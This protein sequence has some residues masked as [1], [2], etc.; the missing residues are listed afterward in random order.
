M[1]FIAHLKI[2]Q[3]LLA[4]LLFPILGLLYF[5]T[6][7]LIEKIQT[8]HDMQGL[9]E[10]TELSIHLSQVVHTIQLER[11]ASSLFLNHQGR[12][13]ASELAHYQERSDQ[14][15]RTVQEFKTQFQTF[16]SESFKLHLDEVFSTFE[17]LQKLREK[18]NNLTTTPKEAIGQYNVINRQLFQFI[19]NTTQLRNYREV[20][21]LKLAYINLLHAKEKAGQER[22]LLVTVFSQ[23]HLKS[24]QFQEFIRLIS[25][26]DT[27]L[28]HEIMNYLTEEQKEFLKSK[29][30]PNNS[31]IE[32]TERLREV[33]YTAA[34]T[35][36]G[37][38]LETV[39]PEHWFT[40]QTRKIEVLKEVA[41]KLAHD[42]YLQAENTQY[43]AFSGFIY[44]S[45]LIGVVLIFSIFFFMTVWYNT[46]QRL[47]QT[48][49]MAN[50]TST[51]HLEELETDGQETM[52]RDEIGQLF[53]ALVDMRSQ[54][55]ARIEANKQISEAALRINQALD[56]V[57]THV[58][59]TDEHYRIIYLNKAAQQ[60]FTREE[61]RFQKYLPQ[62]KA[63]NILGTAFDFFHKNPSH[64]QKLVSGLTSSHH[65]RIVIDNLVLDH[66]IT[67]VIN[68]EGQRLGLV[69]EFNNRS[70][71]VGTEQ[72][73]NQVIQAA[74]QSDFSQRIQLL[75]KTGFFR[76]FSEGINQILDFNQ[77][78]VEDIMH[79]VSALAK[80][81]LTQTIQNEYR[82]AFD[83]LKND[84]NSTIDKLVEIMIVIKETAETIEHTAEELSIGNSRLNQRTETQAASLE[85]TAASMQ[86][87]TSSVQ[88]NAD[89]TKQASLLA[90]QAKIHAEKGGEVVNC[91]IRA[92]TE[93]SNSSARITE[94]IAVI[95]DIAFQ[96]N[97][98]ALNAAVEAARAGEQGRGFAVVATEVRNLAQRSAEAAK[99]IKRLI[100]DSVVKVEEGAKLADQSGKTLTEI[101]TSVKKVSDIIAEIAA[102]TQ[103]QS[104][105]IHQV[106][107]VV[108][109][110][111]EMT[112]QNASMVEEASAASETLRRQVQELKTQVAV[113]KISSIVE[114]TA[115][116]NIS[117]LKDSPRHLKH[118]PPEGEWQDF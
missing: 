44:L 115:S 4:M 12:Q 75:G 103:E 34:H 8:V 116:L 69:L 64:Q 53:K 29:L 114:K 19:L 95:N 18:I 72:E 82:G 66:I 96:T 79:I 49:G 60:L 46:T 62:F 36:E 1:K 57:T 94:I 27:Y 85:Q 65:A 23:T 74:S 81:D 11:G 14:A 67:P 61:V 101:V 58:L 63:S 2:Q 99:E 38:L 84:I 20:F 51:G 98:L 91:A 90:N 55:K 22:A 37:A 45:L 47:K 43:I 89:N 32:E 92:M 104:S 10:L 70:L 80:G 117:T 108:T 28:N 107:N 56:C 26:Q 7:L 21:P 77:Q 9:A 33:I 48:V 40:Q 78:A 35:P 17:Q 97:L 110:M 50:R 93:I 118:A 5:S 87:M 13:F 39:P 83:Q 3:K 15:I 31:I 88:Q 24:E 6:T 102:A 41:D 112:Q 59:I 16:D 25:A 106:N 100:Q 71:E 73:I 105:G 76:S 68:T 42:L 113:F 30:T 109:Q 111:D 52:Y 54:L 86:Q